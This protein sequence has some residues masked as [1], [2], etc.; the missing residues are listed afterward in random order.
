[1]ADDTP[2]VTLDG[3][4]VVYLEPR[5]PDITIKITDTGRAGVLRWA[6]TYGDFGDTGATWIDALDA[7][8]GWL[9]DAQADGR[10]LR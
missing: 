4:E 7:L 10:V 8:T 1:M 5:Q 2:G 9:L 3:R 6:A